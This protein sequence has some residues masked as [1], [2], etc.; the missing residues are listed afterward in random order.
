MVG[1]MVMME[2]ADLSQ[3][4]DQI[5]EMTECQGAM[6]LMRNML[7]DAAREFQDAKAD[8]I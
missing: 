4:V 5:E 6:M 7:T 2:S 3:R 1:T 8:W